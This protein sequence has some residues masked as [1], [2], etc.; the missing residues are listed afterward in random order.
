M[1]TYMDFVQQCFY[2]STGWSWDN[3]YEH[4]LD[5][6][7]NLLHFPIPSGV[8]II[9]SNRNTEHNYSSLEISQFDRLQGSLSY[10]SSSASLDNYYKSSHLL[11]LNRVL[12][13]YRDIVDE[14]DVE[15]IDRPY[16]LYGKM[17]F[18]SQFLEGMFI[19]RFS[20]NYQLITKFVN[21]PRLNKLSQPTSIFT[22][23]FQ[24]TSDNCYHDFIYSTR[25][26]L[27]GFR[28]LYHFNIPNPASQLARTE[29]KLNPIIKPPY[30]STF[31][32]GCELWYATGSVSPGVSIAARYSTY[33][34]SFRYLI[35]SF[36]IYSP[37]TNSELPPF[38][39]TLNTKSGKK[40]IRSIPYAISSIHP[41]TFTL[42]TN[43]LL[44]TCESTYAI[45]SEIHYKKNVRGEETNKLSM[46]KMGITFSSKYQFNI[47]SYESDLILGA[48][49]LRSQIF[50]VEDPN[51]SNLEKPV[52]NELIHNLSR[53]SPHNVVYKVS[54]NE[55]TEKNKATLLP[56]TEEFN[57]VNENRKLQ[58]T[59]DEFIS[60]FKISGSVMKK[61]LRL[62][63]EGKFHDWF[64]SSG[65]SI[66]AD[67]NGTDLKVMK[68]GIEFAFNS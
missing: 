27:F 63:W 39:S 22:F 17:Y 3:T 66:G 42:A 1:I 41:L 6:P 61:N 55:Y 51:N 62:A 58:S 21:T 4:I 68:Y 8:N 25:E 18:P 50:E 26:N 2:A 5:T 32:A 30:P 45:K 31:S 29:K 14:P 59:N 57:K 38:Y 47:Y 67:G 28:C 53:I 36:P 34:D 64:V 43:P 44:G 9:A 46:G 56:K 16:L 48:Q 19:K 12:Q 65:A 52:N 35:N 13:G 24:R 37:L 54:E 15:N 23:Y 11:Q 40:V 10:L 7:R 33:I 60:S 20:S 49:I